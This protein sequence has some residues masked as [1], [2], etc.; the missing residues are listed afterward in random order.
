MAY[1]VLF[2]KDLYY[3]A[4]YDRYVNCVTENIKKFSIMYINP[5]EYMLIS[6]SVCELRVLNAFWN[7]YT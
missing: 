5:M 2:M 7:I 1:D 3:A 4:L 6:Q